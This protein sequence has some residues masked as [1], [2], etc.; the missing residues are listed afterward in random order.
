MREGWAALGPVFRQRIPALGGIVIRVAIARG[1]PRSARTAATATASLPTAVD[2]AS[3]GTSPV[4][5]Q[6]TRGPNGGR[7]TSGAGR[8]TLL[9]F[10]PTTP[11][12]RSVLLG[13]FAF[14]TRRE[15]GPDPARANAG[16]GMAEGAH[17]WAVGTFACGLAAA[18]HHALAF[19]VF[20]LA[21]EDGGRGRR[22][23]GATLA[24]LAGA[25]LAL[26]AVLARRHLRRLLAERD[27][28][29]DFALAIA[30]GL[31]IGTIAGAAGAGIALLLAGAALVRRSAPAG[32]P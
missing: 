3:G 11:C 22:I 4:V 26:A 7:P 32:A 21:A 31:P 12:A 1:R 9:R 30:A 18:G 8:G 29:R 6:P 24:A 14:P 13:S 5:H 17:R 16:S 15:W 19:G 25:P 20:V 27:R 2:S 23:V 10:V 28:E